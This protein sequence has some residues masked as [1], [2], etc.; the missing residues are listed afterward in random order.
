MTHGD[1]K[2]PDRKQPKD[3]DL[4][5]K[6]QKVLLNELESIKSLLIDDS[7]QSDIPVLEE[8]VAEEMLMKNS[9]K[10]KDRSNQNHTPSS[11]A[12]TLSTLP[13]QQSLLTDKKADSKKTITTQNSPSQKMDADTNPFLPDHIRKRLADTSKLYAFDTPEPMPAVSMPQTKTTNLMGTPPEF[14]TLNHGELI[15]ALIEE[16]MPKIKAKLRQKLI[17]ELADIKPNK[18][19]SS[20][21]SSN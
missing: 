19:D 11:S 13:E 12:P 9:S 4:K 21:H 8:V 15:D 5:K 16:F 18:T 3:K 6:E 10:N 14:N 2:K 7:P 20:T 1:D 17:E